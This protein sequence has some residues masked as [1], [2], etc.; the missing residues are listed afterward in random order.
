MTTPEQ[1]PPLLPF[2]V[3]R[4]ES[5]ALDQSVLAIEQALAAD[6]RLDD[7]D[8]TNFLTT[9]ENIRARLAAAAAT[10]REQ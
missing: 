3:I 9:V 8:T 7:N 2:A 4:R 6:S 5:T 10:V 1:D